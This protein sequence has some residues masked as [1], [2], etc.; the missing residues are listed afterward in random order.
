MLETYYE[1]IEGEQT[2]VP[3]CAI[4]Y[5]GRLAQ[6]LDVMLTLLNGNLGDTGMYIYVYGVSDILQCFMS[7]TN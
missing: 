6:K 5:E 4:L 1:V 7:P 3:I 2:F